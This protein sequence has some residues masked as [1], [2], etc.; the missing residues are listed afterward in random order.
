MDGPARPQSVA[1]H[2][3]VFDRHR[4]AAELEVSGRRGIVEGDRR[5]FDEGF[6]VNLVEPADVRR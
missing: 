4:A 1:G 6:F 5:T 2:V 3:E